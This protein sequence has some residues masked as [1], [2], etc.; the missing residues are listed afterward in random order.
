[1]TGIVK[2][3]S[4]FK[5]FESQECRA[6]ADLCSSPSFTYFLCSANVSLYISVLCIV[7]HIHMIYYRSQIPQLLDG[8]ILSLSAKKKLELP[9]C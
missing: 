7:C 4:K 8:A 5:L 3:E 6:I 1:M 2:V 9:K